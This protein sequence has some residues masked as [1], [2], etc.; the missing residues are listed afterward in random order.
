MLNIQFSIFFSNVSRRGRCVI[1][2]ANAKTQRPPGDSFKND[3]FVWG[4]VAGK[5]TSTEMF[6]I[7]CSILNFQGKNRYG[8][9]LLNLLNPLN[10]LN[11]KRNVQY[12]MFNT[13]FSTENPLRRQLFEHFEHFEPSKKNPEKSGLFV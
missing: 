3:A 10:L 11:L 8:D 13:Q 12:S 5:E 2:E 4:D 7:Q 9:N 6:N 1:I